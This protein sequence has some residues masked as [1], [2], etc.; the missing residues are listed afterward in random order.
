MPSAV[1][2]ARPSWPSTHLA[3]SAFATVI[4]L[5]VA[6]MGALGT[7]GEVPTAGTALRMKP[8]AADGL[9]LQADAHGWLH[10][11]WSESSQLLPSGSST[12]NCKPSAAAGFILSAVPAVGTSPTVL[13]AP[14]AATGSRTTVE[15]AESARWAGGPARPYSSPWTASP[16]LAPEK[17]FFP[18]VG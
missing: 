6:A 10:S 18:R 14:M 12:C 16:R 8:A 15:T 7:V 1:A 4:L 17:G 5:P 3:D 13:G 9:Q 11:E 2:A